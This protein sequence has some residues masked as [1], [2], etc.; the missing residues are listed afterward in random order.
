MS[1]IRII[2][3]TFPNEKSA[4]ETA[5][6]LISE[7]LAACV[8]VGAPVESYFMWEGKKCVEKEI[9]VSIKT[10]GSAMK[11]LCKRFKALHPYKCP[12]WIVTNAKASKEYADWVEASCRPD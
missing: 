4:K 2:K 5:E 11:A 3:T 8:H 7:K 1:D 6:L 10:S 9:P 12:Q